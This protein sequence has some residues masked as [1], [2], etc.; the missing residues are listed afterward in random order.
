MGSSKSGFRKC[1]WVVFFGLVLCWWAVAW[2]ADEQIDMQKGR[3][4]WQKQRNGGSLT[5]E[6]QEYLKKVQAE[7]AR[8]RA[9][10]QDPDAGGNARRGGV[11]RE[12]LVRPGRQGALEP[13]DSM[14]LTP[15]TDM[16]KDDKY[17]GESGG[18][19]GNGS[20]V[21]PE[22]LQKAADKQ[23]AKIGPLDADGK[24]AKDGKI[25]FISVG[26]SNTT[27]E[28][29]VFKRMADADPNKAGNVVI[30]DCAQASMA[31]HQWAD[32]NVVT[33]GQEQARSPWDVMDGRIE[34]AGVTA[35]QVQVAWIKLAQIGPARLGEFPRHAKTIEEDTKVILN[36]LMRRFPNLRVAYLGSRIYGGYTR[37]PLNPEPYAYEGAFAVRWSIED[38][39]KGN[40]ELNWD[41]EKGAVK[42]PLL[43]WGP[44]LWADGV[45]GRKVDGLVYLR[46]DLADDGTHP[47]QSGQKKV[48]ELLLD[49]L[50]T[51]KNAKCWYLKK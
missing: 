40:P 29:S 47:S 7:R 30:V 35:K 2:A 50:K 17:K 13:K 16:G 15:L 19:Y 6:E 23:L 9:E 18:L 21:P 10:G 41:A 20:N 43:L 32:P 22:A 42:S 14:G 51:D 38:Q 44:Y 25:V 26:M 3:E 34:R 12:N 46:E 39:M 24:P 45:K 33:R 36:G 11:P 49:F 27:Q 4:L 8:L 37:G 28:F 48:A 1:W 5:A 31:A